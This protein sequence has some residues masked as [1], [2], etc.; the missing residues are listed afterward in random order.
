MMPADPLTSSLWQTRHPG[1]ECLERIHGRK[2][3]SFAQ[4]ERSDDERMNLISCFPAVPSVY[5]LLLFF[6]FPS[7]EIIVPDVSSHVT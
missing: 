6:P 3:C 4:T 5:P 7:P 2:D 1:R